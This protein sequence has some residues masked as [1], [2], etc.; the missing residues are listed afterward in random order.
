LAFD[1]VTFQH[2]LRIAGEFLAAAA[3]TCHP[4]FNGR[5]VFSTCTFAP[6]PVAEA[7][8]KI[9]SVQHQGTSFARPRF[10]DALI[11]AYAR[12]AGATGGYADAYALRAI[13]CMELHVQP[14]VFATCLKELIAAGSAADPVVYT[15]LPFTPPPQG[16]TYVEV[17]KRRIGKLK[18]KSNRGG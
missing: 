17:A 2:L 11:K 6:D 15:E 18:I 8:A 12:I 4:E 16:E 14:P 1:S 3:T 7:S 9:V 5:T 13:V 10:A